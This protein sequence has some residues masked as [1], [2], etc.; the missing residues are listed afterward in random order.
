MDTRLAKADQENILK[1]NPLIANGYSYERMKGAVDYI[2]SVMKSAFA[3]LKPI[4]FTY[5]D[6][7]IPSLIE[8][9]DAMSRTFRKGGSGKKALEITKTS[10]YPITCKVRFT[11]PSTGASA[12]F[13]KNVLVTFLEKGNVFYNK[14]SKYIIAPKLGDRVFSLD[15]ESIYVDISRSKMVFIRTPYYFNM[16][17]VV[18]STDIHRSKLYH[19]QKNRSGKP[20][21]QNIPTLVNYLLAE[22]GLQETYKR[23]FGVDVIAVHEDDITEERF[24]SDKY[25]ICRSHGKLRAKN[26]VRTNNALIFRTSQF[27]P[28]LMHVIAATFF[29]MDN[30]LD[31]PG[32]QLKNLNSR[33]GWIRALANWA[34][35]ETDE[36]AAYEK[37]ESHIDGVKSY[38]DHT[39]HVKFQKEGYDI[40]D[41]FDLFKYVIQNFS[42]IAS[43]HDV[44]SLENKVLSIVPHFLY[45][46]TSS[47]F[48]MMFELQKQAAKRE[49]NISQVKKL[50]Q[51][52]WKEEA[53]ISRVTAGDN[54]RNLDHASDCM[55]VKATRLMVPQSKPGKGSKSQAEMQNPAFAFHYSKVGLISYQF[56]NK[57][58]PTALDSLNPFAV[59]EDGDVLKPHPDAIPVIENMKE[60]TVSKSTL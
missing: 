55:V 11:E 21:E 26:I 9:M 7:D 50:I 22:C 40:K 20:N 35:D 53:A 39:T 52:N 36:F 41:T 42:V 38:I 5:V 49:L 2:H 46:L 58:C 59:I 14:G 51:S 16:D 8:G 4:G 25:V 10:C 37:I 24:P 1:F 18:T 6:Y 13:H 60:L 47:I 48:R 29:I 44:A 15:K 3:T 57:S 28:E 34:L 33:S 12:V 43:T 54:V 27:I 45:N 23:F 56:V 19:G 30:R 31:C 17:G 32:M